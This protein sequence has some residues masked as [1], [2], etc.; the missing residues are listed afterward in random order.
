MAS[1]PFPV[2][3]GKYTLLR[4]IGRPSATLYLAAAGGG[5]DTRLCVVRKTGDAASV[6][7]AN[8]FREEARSL[9]RLD[10]PNVVRVVDAGQVYGDFYVAMAL[11]EGR[12]LRALGQRL[13]ERGRTLPPSVALGIGHEICRGLA[14]VH[15]QHASHRNLTPGNV[16]VSWAGEVKLT[17]FALSTST[18]RPIGA[19]VSPEQANRS[20]GDFRADI[21]AAGGILWELL[22]GRSLLGEAEGA[23]PD[24]AI[25]PPSRFAPGVT[26]SLDATVMRALEVD[27]AKRWPSAEALREAIAREEGA[28]APVTDGGTIAELVGELWEGE[29]DRERAELEKLR[30]DAVVL[31]GERRPSSV[32]RAAA[33]EGEAFVLPPPRTLQGGSPKMASFEEE[34]DVE[35]DAEQYIG[36][37]IGGRYRVDRILGQGG[38]GWVYEVEHIEIGKRLALKILLPRFSRQAHLVHRFRRE[39]R[40]A[41]TI[42]HPNIVDVTDS[43]TTADDNFY[44]VMEKLEGVELGMALYSERRF[45]PERAVHIGVQM[46]RGLAA[47]HSHGIIHRDL[48]PENIY[49]ISRDGDADFVKVLDFGI[50]KSPDEISPRGGHGV[51]MGTPE[52]MAPEQAAGRAIDARIDVYSVGAIIYEM[53]TGVPPH[54]GPTAIDILT[55]KASERPR[56]VRLLNPSV[57]EPLERVIHACL[58]ID[59]DLRPSS[60]SALEYELT[61]CMKGRGSAVAGVLGIKSPEPDHW[62]GPI[63]LTAAAPPALPQDLGAQELSKAQTMPLPSSLGAAV[64]E[65]GARDAKWSPGSAAARDTAAPGESSEIGHAT[66]TKPARLPWALLVVLAITMLAVGVVVGG[67]RSRRNPAPESSSQRSPGPEARPLA[68]P[69]AKAVEPTQPLAPKAVDV[70]VLLDWAQRA[71]GGGRLVGPPGDNLKELLAR[72]ERDDPGNAVAKGLRA[73]AMIG[74]RARVKEALYQRRIDDAIGAL[75]ALNEFDPADLDARDRLAGAL[76]ERCAKRAT[77]NQIGEAISDGKAAVELAPEDPRTCAA[78]ADALLAAGRRAD[79]AEEYRR[80][81]ALAPEDLHARRQLA[82][83]LKPLET[84]KTKKSA[85]SSNLSNTRK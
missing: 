30:R 80:V 54:S 1:F 16:L 70:G 46:C 13:G 15:S 20:G 6:M 81:I 4:S 19:W 34:I 79:A 40:A 17:D 71:L 10:H 66:L 59:P 12:D 69:S 84:A 39:A 26:R 2:A 82:E 18:V 32:S 25:L 36:E 67:W 21:W 56:A 61:K 65:P 76:S 41:S 29:I 27:P 85:K 43:G 28:I 37:L 72:I 52:Y 38:M 64:N 35:P 48:K 51:A 60:M 24:R 44:F 57:P 73:Q 55:R 9:V 62:S 68:L 83:T 45:A 53:V 42:G 5:D 50:A 47:A 31:R 58:E 7:A 14:W 3:F 78:L 23:D 8:R 11:V 22:T 63:P 49:L 74:L 33:V 77:A 75:R